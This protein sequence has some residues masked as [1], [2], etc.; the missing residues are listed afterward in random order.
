MSRAA[1]RSI[2][3]LRKSLHDLEQAIRAGRLKPGAPE[4]KHIIGKMFLASFIS[5]ALPPGFPGA[6]GSVGKVAVA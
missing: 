1:H 4:T 2:Q 5:G 6:V 3:R